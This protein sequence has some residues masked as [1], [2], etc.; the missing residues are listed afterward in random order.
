MDNI[1]NFQQDSW[2]AYGVDKVAISLS[3]YLSLNK[4]LSKL[5]QWRMLQIVRKQQGHS[6]SLK[7]E[8]LKDFQGQSVAL[9]LRP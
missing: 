4:L 9:C 8:D 5:L 3:L 6:T 2:V 7:D 1:L